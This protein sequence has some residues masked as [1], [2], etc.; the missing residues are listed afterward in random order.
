MSFPSLLDDAIEQL[1]QNNGVSIGSYAPAGL[2]GNQ[3]PGALG[4]PSL[5]LIL[6]RQQRV[7]MLWFHRSSI[8]MLSQP[9]ENCRCSNSDQPRLEPLQEHVTTKVF[10]TGLLR[11]RCSRSLRN[12][13][14]GTLTLTV[15]RAGSS[16]GPRRGLCRLACLSRR[17]LERSGAWNEETNE[18]AW[19]L[20]RSLVQQHELWMLG[21]KS[22]MSTLYVVLY[23]TYCISASTWFARKG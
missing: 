6:D 17:L 21:A 14:L 18:F 3:W 16:C 13:G 19:S 2:F 20:D 7:P 9:M 11:Q 15:G 1:E 5:Y 10:L 12:S 4:R 23:A 8:T 22:I